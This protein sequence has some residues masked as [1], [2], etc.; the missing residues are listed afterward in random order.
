MQVGDS[1]KE[2]AQDW[3]S[4]NQPKALVI[5]GKILDQGSGVWEN[6]KSES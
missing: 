5:N 4:D 3:M 2:A 1:G 6:R